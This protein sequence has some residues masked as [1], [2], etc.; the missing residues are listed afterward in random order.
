M[1]LIYPYPMHLSNGYTYMLSISQYLNELSNHL[2]VN[3]LSLDSRE[4]FSRYLADVV[5]L[6]LNPRMHVEAISN[7]RFGIKSNK[8][9]FSDNV[10]SAVNKR[11]EADEPKV[12]YTRDFKQMRAMLKKRDQLSNAKFVFEAHQV[13]SQ[14]YA[15]EGE[16]AKAE[17]M[18]KLEAFVFENVDALVCIT[19]TLSREITKLFPQASDVRLILPVGFSPSFLAIPASAER[20]CEFDLIYSGNFS[21]WKGID[22]LITALAQVKQE[23]PDFKTLLIGVNDRE[24]AHYESLIETQGLSENV[25]LLGRVSHKEIIGYVAKS[26]MGVLPNSYDGD[27]L[28]F[29][30]PLKLYEYLGAGIKV[31]C[32]RLPPIESTIPADLLYWA[33]PENSESLASAILLA[34]RDEDHE[35]DK[36]RRY[37]EGFTWSKRAARFAEFLDRL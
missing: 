26:R 17:E 19:P 2:Q 11:I 34:H 13:L 35:A 15:R 33:T 24:R 5:D 10:I 9:F 20:E 23:E 30:S 12:F 27:G 25:S 4:Q 3:L 31:I 21:K 36:L 6:Q 14:N 18:Q 1:Q 29:T 7:R 28:L 32:S 16:Y 8:L 37:A 22:Y